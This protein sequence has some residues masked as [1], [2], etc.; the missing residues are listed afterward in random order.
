M[1][2]ENDNSGPLTPLAARGAMTPA[3]AHGI[4]PT[5]PVQQALQMDTDQSYRNSLMQISQLQSKLNNIDQSK[6]IKPG[7][8]PTKPGQNGNKAKLAMPI[9]LNKDGSPRMPSGIHTPKS[10][11][12]GQQQP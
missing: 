5:T 2:T 9:V 4:G 6:Y 8:A 10:Q 11:A 1:G 7:A 12:G 3:T